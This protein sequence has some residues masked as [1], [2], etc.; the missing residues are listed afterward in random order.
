MLIER[1]NN[2]T[3][4]KGF[5]EK[6]CELLAGEIREAIISKTSKTGGHLSSN[7][8]IVEATIA[9]HYVFNSPVDKIVFD[10]SHQCYTHKILTGRGRAYTDETCYKDVSGYTNPSESEHDFF[11]FGHTSTSISLA[12]GMAK[13]RDLQNEK[14]NVIAVI[15]DA[16][17]CGGEALEGL[18][19]AG[20][21]LKSNLIVVLNDNQMSIAE[22]HGG[23]FNV[24]KNLRDNKGNGKCN[25]FTEMGF[26]YHFVENGNDIYSL[27]DVF[28]EVKDSS[29]PVIVHICTKKGKGF[30]LAEDYA[31]DTHFIKPFSRDLKT[32]DHDI[33]NERYDI[34]ARNLL[35][36]KMN[37][38]SRVV[39]ITAA[40]PVVLSLFGDFRDRIGRQYIDVGIAEEAAVSMAGGMA[41]NG[42]KPVVFTRATFFQRAYDQIS[43]EICINNLPITMLLINGSVYAPTDM[44]HIGIFC[45]AMMSNIPNL[46]MLAPTNKQEYLKMLEWSIEQNQYPVAIFPPR[47]GVYN[48]ETETEDD[49]SNLNK[50]KLQKKGNKVAIIAAGDF[51]QM[52]EDVVKLLDEQLEITASL[53]NPRYLS[54]LDEDMLS[55]L[56][57][58]HD[59]IVTLEDGILDGGF[60]QKVAAFY[61]QYNVCVMTYGLKKAFYDNYDVDK[62]LTE[63]RLKPDMIVE[64]IK[65]Q[66]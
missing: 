48:A 66:L 26:R 3:D 53:I 58:T 61:G 27:I 5:S 63:N 23:F 7:L 35:I 13:A 57:K 18:N 65:R 34:L 24:L 54:G 43:Q 21:E 30:A 11:K 49:Y 40:M 17:L 29:A 20:A 45:I 2:P 39:A 51:Y 25:L 52:G 44:T 64:D 41:A 6:E 37:R 47:N 32:I 10:T 31:E 46:V 28:S 36:D 42:G 60:G 55:Q 12:C 38:D 56:S 4:L 62:V 1:I 33:P 15:G 16:A 8:G 50:F 9:L 22:N 59:I 14:Y 19:Y